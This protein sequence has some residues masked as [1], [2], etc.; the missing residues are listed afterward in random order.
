LVNWLQSSVISLSEKFLGANVAH[1][2]LVASAMNAI[3]ASSQG[4]RSYI[5]DQREL[6][7]K[8]TDVRLNKFVQN[9]SGM[10]MPALW[11]WNSNDSLLM[12]N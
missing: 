6:S 1:A 7:E 12:H 2:T 9:L 4:V 10:I 5:Q 3:W 8:E 11:L